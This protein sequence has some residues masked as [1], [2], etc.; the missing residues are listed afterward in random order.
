MVDF[1]VGVYLCWLLLGVWLCLVF[2]LNRCIRF[3]CVLCEVWMIVVL[4]L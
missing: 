4:L 2:V 1:D 3:V